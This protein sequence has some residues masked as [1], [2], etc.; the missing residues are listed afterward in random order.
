MTKGEVCEGKIEF[1]VDSRCQLVLLGIE[2]LMRVG[3]NP[4]SPPL[5]PSLDISSRSNSSLRLSISIKLTRRTIRCENVPLNCMETGFALQRPSASQ[6]LA[7]QAGVLLL[8][9][10]QLSADSRLAKRYILVT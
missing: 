8:A 2:T 10:C 4:N 7:V 1:R 9:V 5:K 6:M 3:L